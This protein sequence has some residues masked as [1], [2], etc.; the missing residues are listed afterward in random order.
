MHIA[1]YISYKK[2]NASVPV[3]LK[4]CHIHIVLVQIYVVLVQYGS[5]LQFL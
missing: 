3:N 1:H 2:Q 5:C 4:Q